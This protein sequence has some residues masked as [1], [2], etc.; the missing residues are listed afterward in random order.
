[1]DDEYFMLLYVT[2]IYKAKL[3]KLKYVLIFH[4]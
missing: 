2:F 4:I 3:P 1:M